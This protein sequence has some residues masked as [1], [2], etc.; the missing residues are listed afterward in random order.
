[1]RYR[2]FLL[3]ERER[4]IAL[5][6][7]ADAIAKMRAEAAAADDG[8]TADANRPLNE[9]ATTIEEDEFTFDADDATDEADV[10]VT[11]FHGRSWFARLFTLVPLHRLFSRCI[12]LTNTACREIF[13]QDLDGIFHRPPPSCNEVPGDSVVLNGESLS[14]LY[15]LK[16][17][18]GAA[19]SAA[20][21]TSDARFSTLRAAY[22]ADGSSVDFG[23]LEGLGAFL[24]TNAT[25]MIFVDPGW[26]ASNGREVLPDGSVRSWDLSYKSWRNLT[27]ADK[28][29]A[30]ARH[31][32]R[33]VDAD[34]DVSAAR[35]LS[36]KT[37]SSVDFLAWAAADFRAMPVVLGEKLKSRWAALEKVVGAAPR[38][39]LVAEEALL[40]TVKG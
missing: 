20:I 13:G 2:R 5:E 6:L 24:S 3:Q 40:E 22:V 31:W 30:R 15:T 37:T 11:Q 14:V 34:P 9:D 35:A 10:E 39:A 18:R 21:A 33:E 25:R 27:C 38:L 16:V 19:R 8:D 4:W 32:M 12:T 36:P 7:G 28:R 29:L 1:M 26:I 17:K 23:D